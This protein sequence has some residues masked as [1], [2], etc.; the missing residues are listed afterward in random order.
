ML[1]DQGQ[2][3]LYRPLV[4]SP[5]QAVLLGM[6][7]IAIRR[8]DESGRGMLVDSQLLGELIFTAQNRGLIDPRAHFQFNRSPLPQLDSSG[9]RFA[10]GFLKKEGFLH[11]PETGETIGFLGTSYLDVPTGAFRHLNF[12]GFAELVEE[13]T[14]GGDRD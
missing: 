12:F 1:P 8:N 6:I 9:V 2:T 3:A 11:I 10:L 5:R 14:T 7:W 4:L 13:F